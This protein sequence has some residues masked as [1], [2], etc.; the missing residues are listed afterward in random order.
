MKK[1]GPHKSQSRS[2]FPGCAPE[3]QGKTTVHTLL[4]T[5]KMSLLRVCHTGSVRVEW[6]GALPNPDAVAEEGGAGGTDEEEEAPLGLVETGTGGAGELKRPAG[7]G[8]T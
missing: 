1:R 6:T 7:T 5:R 2:A 4:A 8:G 3:K